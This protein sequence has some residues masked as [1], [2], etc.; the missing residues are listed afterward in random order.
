M[1]DSEIDEHRYALLDG[2]T[3]DCQQLVGASPARLQAVRTASRRGE[4]TCPV[5]AQTLTAKLG[6]QVRWHFA[7]R[8]D[9]E[10]RF[11]EPESDPHKK[12]KA[13][14]LSW[15]LA[16]HPGAQGREEWRLPAIAQIADV[17]VQ[18]VGRRPL[19]LEIQYADLAASSWRTRHAGYESLGLDDIWFLGHTRLRL[20]KAGKEAFLDQLSSALVGARHPLLYLNGRSGFVTQLHVSPAATFRAAGG[21][22]LGWTPVLSVKAPLETLRMDGR[23]PILPERAR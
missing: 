19:V 17:L 18:P 10:Y 14:L 5:C 8:A 23:T 7:H 13:R 12:A 4:L 1:A 3:V 21:E 15:G 11:H 16:L 20:R 9:C 2:A 6:E 22:R